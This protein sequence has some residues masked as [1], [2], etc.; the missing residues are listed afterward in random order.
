M[1][2]LLY[3]SPAR[4]HLYPAM[5][6]AS[7]LAARG[8]DTRV[9][10]LAA[11]IDHVRAAGLDAAPIDPAIEAH[12]IVD[13]KQRLAPLAAL[14]VLRTFARRS[15]LEAPDLTRA[16]ER[17]AP[18]VLLIDVNC[19]GAATAAEASGLPW[20]VYSPYLLP[21]RSREAPPFGLGLAPRSGP[22]GRARDVALGAVLSAS[23]DR[24]AMPTIN[25]L[26]TQLGLAPL[27]SYEAQLGRPHA[28]LALTAEG[29]E[30]P[31]REWPTNVRFV[32]P[33]EWSPPQPAPPWLREM[34]DPLVLVTCSTERQRDKRLLHVALE[35]LPPVGMAVLGTAAAHDPGEFAPPPGSRVERFVP[36]DHVLAGAACVVCHGGMGIVQKAL[37]AEVPL[38]V[39]PFGRD[40]L[41]VACRVEEAQAGA[42]L[43][44]RRLTPARLRQ[45]VELAM[46][47]RA[48]A[49]RV[50]AAFAAAG[51]ASAA[52]DAVE[53]VVVGGGSDHTARTRA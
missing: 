33:M 13:W 53:G 35:A 23:F 52:A 43:S 28:L 18:D 50:S 9:Q 2:I 41:D 8:H 4:G 42:Q 25:R 27:P 36:H 46:T 40:Q 12:A 48:G 29:F 5:P 16:I 7:E 37:A 6:I 31:R 11:E 44:P 32:G 17:D 45:A 19:W 34:T 22:L 24:T 20:A 10:T 3:T 51:G 30:Y 15:E 38:V 21:L 49:R 39:V 47:L 14:S 26:R 1:R